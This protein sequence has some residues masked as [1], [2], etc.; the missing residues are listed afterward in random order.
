MLWEYQVSRYGFHQRIDLA[1][2]NFREGI[3]TTR[4]ANFDISGSTTCDRDGPVPRVPGFLQPYHKVRCESGS[5][6][7][8][9]AST[10]KLLNLR[11][12]SAN[13]GDWLCY[14]KLERPI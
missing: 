6:V 4:K 5:L 8:L 3:R 10:W 13:V 14:T 7:V 9:K 2:C 12:S 1:N 11:A